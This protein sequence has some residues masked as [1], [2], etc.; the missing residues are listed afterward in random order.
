MKK[1]LLILGCLFVMGCAKTTF[2]SSL[3][4]VDQGVQKLTEAPQCEVDPTE[5]IFY[6]KILSYDITSTSGGSF[7]F[8]L[9]SGLLRAFDINFETKTGEMETAISVYSPMKFDSNLSP[10]KNPAL[11]I[12][13]K[14]EK[15]TDGGFK[16][17]IDISQF[18]LG[19]SYYWSTPF[20]RLTEKGLRSSLEH[21]L[22]QLSLNPSRWKTV[23]ADLASGYA[24]VPVGINAGVRENDE[25]IFYNVTYAWNGEP[26][27][28]FLM[29]VPTTKDPIAKGRVIRVEQNASAIEIV[30]LNPAENIKVGSQ[31]EILNLPKANPNEKRSLLRA[32]K[33]IDM[34]PTPIPVKGISQSVDLSSYANTQFRALLREYG[35]YLRK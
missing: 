13:D 4:Q 33:V 11:V 29:P 18:T 19:G 9:L 35:F 16:A 7:G 5:Y 25:F 8:N 22:S 10:E 34:N 21:A 1:P 23:V 26:C 20:S 28:D 3:D 24:I 27:S 17:N 2:Q 14:R 32:V 15:I 31:V 6:P 30:I 12:G